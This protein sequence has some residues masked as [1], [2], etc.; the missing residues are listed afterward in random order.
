M[1][2][3][4]ELKGKCF[5]KNWDELPLYPRLVTFKVS[6]RLVSLLQNTGISPNAVTIFSLF[7]AVIAALFFA[8]GNTYKLMIGALLLEF[9]YVLDCTDGQLARL[10]GLCSKEGAFVDYILNYIVHPIVFFSIGLGCYFASGKVLFIISGVISGWSMV[11]GYA[12]SDCKHAVITAGLMKDNTPVVASAE[13]VYRDN[14]ER[15]PLFKRFFMAMHK[16]ST[17]PTIMNIITIAS[18]VAVVSGSMKPAY[19]ITILFAA[20]SS[21]VFVLRACDI[22]K[23]G[24]I[25]AE[26]EQVKR[27]VLIKE[28]SDE[29]KEI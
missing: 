24:R 23:G 8:S 29:S 18:I 15:D 1:Y 3:I 20:D 11:L 16:I 4:A 13:E 28:I 6:I 22:I 2:T 5:K 14:V 10:K 19:F 26:Y 12:L 9:Y 27:K 17:Y 7:V 21:I 25:S